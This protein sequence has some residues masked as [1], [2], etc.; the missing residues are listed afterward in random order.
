VRADLGGDVD[1]V[2]DGGPCGVGVES[3]IVDLTAPV[4]VVLRPGAVTAEDLEAV[5]GA[6]VE[7]H[8]A[9]PARAPGMLAAHYAPRARVVLCAGP[10][11]AASVVAAA[12][13]AGRRADVLDPR[14]YAPAWARSL[15]AW[16]RDAD[17]RGLDLLA[18]VPPAA[19]GVGVAVL[20]RLRRAATGSG[21]SPGS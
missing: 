10:D 4:P 20:D 6:P 1:L 21:G 19:E 2:L 8:A 3:T 17:R 18:V 7:R 11:E 15:Y 14:V 16:L 12:R 13:A 9:G 5:L